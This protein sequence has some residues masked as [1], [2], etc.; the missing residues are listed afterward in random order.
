MLVACGGGGGG[1]IG[2]ADG[3]IRGTG[4]SVGPVS[5]FGSVIVNGVR[6]EIEGNNNPVQSND[7]ISTQDELDEGMILR[8]DGEW[9]ENGEGSADLVEYDDTLR[10]PLDSNIVWDD[11]TQT[12]V[13]SILGLDVNIDGQTVIK[14]APTAT[15]LAQDDMVRVSGWRLPGGDFRASL[16]RVHSAP[17]SLFDV[18]N[19]IELEGEI[20]SY[21]P[22]PCSF[23][24][25]S[26]LVR[27]NDFGIT[28]DGI[29]GAELEN[30]LFVEVEGNLGSVAGELDA[31]EIRQ[32]D[33]RRYRRGTDDD[34]E[35]AGPVT[36][37][38]DPVT[39][40]FV[41]NGINVNITLETEF[42]DD[43]SASDLVSGLLIQVEGDYQDDDTVNAD[44]INLREANAEVKGSVDKDSIERQQQTFSIG[45]VQVR[46]SPLT[47]IENDDDVVRLT[48]DQLFDALASGDELEIEGI[49]REDESGIFIEAL[50]IEREESEEDGDEYQL[51]GKLRTVTDSSITVLGVE[52][53]VEFAALGCTSTE[54]QELI[55]GRDEGFPVIEVEYE[56]LD[57]PGQFSYR[58]TEIES[59]DDE[60][61]EIECDD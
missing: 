39:S 15:D 44:E 24:I 32:D 60:G 38:F 4:S 17:D 36:V 31:F 57:P 41:I 53:A 54:L 50:K 42:D 18:D 51:E 26:V 35:F 40:S 49:E 52:M 46:V 12:G 16:V 37:D 8:V 22:D 29:S 10:G 11:I 47:L 34:I 59:D 3:G 21:Q 14:G 45:G 20:R 28:F 23:E 56:P 55:D 1:G 61:P 2:I 43:L 5:G 58:A 33:Q 27:C 25:G 48:R 19:E 9:R 7:G 30:G 6:L 13:V